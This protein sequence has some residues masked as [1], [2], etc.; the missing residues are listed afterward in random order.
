MSDF[1]DY[2]ADE[3]L[4]ERAVRRLVEAHRQE[5]DELTG[6]FN[7]EREEELERR[8]SDLQRELLHLKGQNP[9]G[10]NVGALEQT[11]NAIAKENDRLADEVVGLTRKLEAKTKQLE[12]IKRAVKT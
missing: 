10:T 5:Y 1:I 7:A 9:N 4:H 12:S 11:A 3:P 8:I 2:W 6:A